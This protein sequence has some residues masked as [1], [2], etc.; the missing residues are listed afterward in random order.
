MRARDLQDHLPVSVCVFQVIAGVSASPLKKWL[1][2]R[3]MAAKES[4]L[5][6]YD[7]LSSLSLCHCHSLHVISGVLCVVTPCGTI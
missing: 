2:D 3:A 5:K 6:R 4:E 7:F 1:F